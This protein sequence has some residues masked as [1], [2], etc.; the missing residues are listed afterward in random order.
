MP[1]QPRSRYAPL[2]DIGTAASRHASAIANALGLALGTSGPLRVR[3]FPQ[4]VQGDAAWASVELA[5]EGRFRVLGAVFE[6]GSHLTVARMG[7]RGERPALI[8][9]DNEAAA[10]ALVA[11]AIAAWVRGGGLVTVPVTVFD[12][13]CDALPLFAHQLPL[14]ECWWRARFWGEWDEHGGS[15][16]SVEPAGEAGWHS[17]L[18]ITQDPK[19][20]RLTIGGSDLVPLV[21]RDVTSLDTLAAALVAALEDARRAV[22]ARRAYQERPFTL[23]LAGET[24]LA[25]LREDGVAH[26]GWQLSVRDHFPHGYDDGVIERRDHGGQHFELL[27][28][29]GLDGV[30]VSAGSSGATYA[31]LEALRAALPELV[32]ATRVHRHALTPDKLAPGEY[33]R[34][35]KAFSGLSPGEE[36]RFAR[37]EYVPREGLANYHFH[38]GGP[39]GEVA[40]SEA[41]EV[42]SEVLGHLDE[43]LQ[44]AK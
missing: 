18:T 32:R 43:Y 1:P 27:L 15:G 24:L 8:G 16:A 41:G 20:V 34:V 21:R 13:A 14:D 10:P 35:K 29:E 5:V 42:E 12:A 11:D 7:T 33:Y 37:R 40:L 22:I 30:G 38:R 39:G 44:R 6:L 31:S 9:H 3:V 26:K 17:L 19:G 23:R 2:M 25:A 4:L 28:N 36:L